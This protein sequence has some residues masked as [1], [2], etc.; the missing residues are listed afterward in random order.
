MRARSLLLVLLLSPCA[1]TAAVRI[2]FHWPKPHG[3]PGSVVLSVRTGS[4]P[5]GC[6]FETD[7]AGLTLIPNDPAGSFEASGDFVG[8]CAQQPLPSGPDTTTATRAPEHD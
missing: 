4:F 5:A 6:S 7:S 1:A 8:S 3:G 2:L